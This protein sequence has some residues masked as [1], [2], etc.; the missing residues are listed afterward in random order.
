MEYSIK[1][2]VLRALVAE[3]R[4]WISAALSVED[5]KA[6]PDSAVINALNAERARLPN[7][8]TYSDETGIDIEIE[9]WR[10]IVE[11]QGRR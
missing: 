3:R 7:W 9:R 8:G 5:A 1:L 11:G 10:S 6:I 4:A 2:D